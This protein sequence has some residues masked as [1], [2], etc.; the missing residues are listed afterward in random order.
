MTGIEV[1][2]VREKLKLTPAQF[3]ELVGATSSTVYRWESLGSRHVG[4][5][6][7]ARRVIALADQQVSSRGDRLS[8]EVHEAMGAGGG[9]RG[10]Y[11]LLRCA[12]GGDQGNGAATSAA[13]ETL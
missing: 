5:E 7:H 4:M 1:R 10:L 9:L 6:N 2:A 12:F 11:C 8:R 13:G 3:G